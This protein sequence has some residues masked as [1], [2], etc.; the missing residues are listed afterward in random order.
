MHAFQSLSNIILYERLEELNSRS[1]ETNTVFNLARSWKNA[2]YD[3]KKA[4]VMI[5]I[6][7]IEIAEY[8]NAKI[9]WNI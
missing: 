5:M 7:K 6:H 3:R 1:D 9:L 4:V 2:D 8:G